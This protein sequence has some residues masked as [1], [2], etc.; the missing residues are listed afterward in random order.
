MP[1]ARRPQTFLTDFTC[2]ALFSTLSAPIP[3]DTP[4][5]RAMWM[6][7]V[8]TH[9]STDLARLLQLYAPLVRIMVVHLRLRFPAMFAECLDEVVSDGFMGLIGV[10]QNAK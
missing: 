3:G 4:E 9:N 10:I 6:S 1:R 2:P 5:I 7:F 8:K